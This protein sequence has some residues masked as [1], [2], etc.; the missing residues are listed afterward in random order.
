[1]TTSVDGMR[2]GAAAAPRSLPGTPGRLPGPV[3]GAP[4]GDRLPRAP[5]R[6]R[7]VPAI[8]GALILLVSAVVGGQLALHKQPEA[9]M[10]V[11]ARPVSAGHVLAAADLSSTKM[12]AGTVH[13]FAST[14]A[15]QLVGRRVAVSLPAGTL[16]SDALLSG[17]DAPGPGQQ[18]V[19]VALKPGAFPPAL[20]VG[21]DVSVLQVPAAGGTGDRS[22]T[23]LVERARVVGIEPDTASG[24]SVLS[25]A[26]DAAAVLPVARASA[27]GAVSVS[28]LPVVE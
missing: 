13:A 21:R 15:G 5:R 23:V 25:L 22:A 16:L 4:P 17:A 24:I 10:V 11:L 20:E 18:V 12:S 27:A 26:I 8:S 2:H 9:T 1:M 7:P 19:A 6:R 3:N 14:D 28:L